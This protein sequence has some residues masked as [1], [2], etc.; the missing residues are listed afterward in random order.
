MKAYL[1]EGNVDASPRDPSVIYH[2]G[3]YYHT[4][5]YQGSLY[6]KKSE[7]IEGLY[8]ATRH[9]VFTP[10]APINKEIWAP[11]LFVIDNK[12]YIYVAID[13]GNNYHHRMYVVSNDSNDPLTP[14]THIKKLADKTD[15]WA[16]DGTVLKY[17]NELYFVWSGW[18]GDE[19]LAQ[20]IY[21]AHMK[22]PTEIDGD[23]HL[24]SSP[25]YDWEKNDCDGIEN[26]RPFI[27]EGPFAFYTD[28][29]TYI[30]YSGSGCWGNNYCLGAL[31]F[32]GG[33]IL[34]KANWEKLKEPLFKRNKDVNGP[35]HASF[36]QNS[37]DGKIYMAYHAFKGDCSLG[38]DATYA[39]IQEVKVEN[40]V[41]ILGEPVKF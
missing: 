16:I 34:D 2:D 29:S 21:I 7:T 35:G 32:R 19:N 3:Y 26:S 5:S 41:P 28:K 13:D 17:Q 33:D 25:E 8:K 20:H 1:L 14:Y 27:N 37:P 38:L 30:I 40:D 11:E 24:I 23:R 4:S 6:I 18:I 12:C 15:K 9:K 22:N 39:V 36:I 31:R 10:D